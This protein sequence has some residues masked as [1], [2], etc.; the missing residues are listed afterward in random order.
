MLQQAL[1]IVPE[2]PSG[3]V[4]MPVAPG[5]HVGVAVGP[6]AADGSGA[7]QTAPHTIRRTLRSLNLD[8]TPAGST[9]TRCTR[10]GAPTEDRRMGPCAVR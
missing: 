9:G 8:R 5:P 4:A 1:K 10:A 6:P 7:L 3:A 2:V